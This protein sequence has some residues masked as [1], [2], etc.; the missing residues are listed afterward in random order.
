M[1][2]E[3]TVS[4]WRLIAANKMA[5]AGAAM[6]LAMFVLAIVAPL[7]CKDPGAV[8]ISRQLQSPGFDAWLGTDDLGRDVFSRIAYGARISLLVGFVA[9]GIATVIGIFLGAV[10]G[11]YGG[12]I[13]TLVM[14]FVDIMLCF[15][16]FFL[17]LVVIAFLEPSIWNIM[18]IIGLTGWMGVARL[19]RAEFMSL[20]HRD[21][22]LAIRSLG[23]SDRR[24]IFRHILPNALSPVLVSAALGVAGAILTE[25]ALSFLGIGVQPPTPSW[26]N[27]L[28]AGKQTLGTA[29]W[30]SFFPGVAVLITV[31]G[32][33]LLGE[34]LRDAL[35]PRLKR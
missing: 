24:I 3:R 6:V 10:A 23:A 12:W 22:V 17:I 14:R 19:V 4:T 27:M 11:Y 7:I 20:R 16:S 13:D 31:L 32:Y 21:F 15:P 28:I 25:S 29:W 30:L 1:T 26:G 9:V 18:V 8:D 35:D 33:N 2:D 34:G 5:M